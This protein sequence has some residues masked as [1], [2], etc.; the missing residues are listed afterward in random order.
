[1]VARF[2]AETFNGN[3]LVGWLALRA[4]PSPSAASGDGKVD[5]R[6]RCV[7]VASAC[8]AGKDCR[9]ATTSTNIGR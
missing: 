3:L 6:Y 8:F 9:S 1:M 4:S 2:F 7:H 5:G